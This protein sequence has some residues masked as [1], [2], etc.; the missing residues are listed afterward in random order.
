MDTRTAPQRV[1]VTYLPI[2]MQKQFISN[3]HVIRGKPCKR[4]FIPEI[5][6]PIAAAKML[7]PG[8]MPRDQTLTPSIRDRFRLVDCASDF[9]DNR[10]TLYRSFSSGRPVNHHSNLAVVTLGM[11]TRLWA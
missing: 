6:V 11:T 10:Y 9:P 2:S 4:F 1:P 3:L 7:R 5:G 8:A